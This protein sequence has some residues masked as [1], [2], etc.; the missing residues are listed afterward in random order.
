[1]KYCYLTFRSVTFA[2]RAEGVLRKSGIDASLIR[3]PKGL[4]DRGCG[5]SLR[6]REQDALTAADKVRG[7]GIS[8]G[9]L[10]CVDSDGKAGEWPL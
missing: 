8:M 2:Q 7:A 5:Y 4:S 6:L 3:T 9:K 1:M 10:L